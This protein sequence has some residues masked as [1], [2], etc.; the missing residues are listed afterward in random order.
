MS[1]LSEEMKE[2]LVRG[3]NTDAQA[4]IQRTQGMFSWA[5]SQNKLA[6]GYMDLEQLTYIT[7]QMRLK[8]RL[9]GAPRI[10]Q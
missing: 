4:I 5:D 2:E 3:I 8:M 10:N 1:E 9:L 7:E 6:I